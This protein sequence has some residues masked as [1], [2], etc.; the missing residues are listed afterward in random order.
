VPILVQDPD[1]SLPNIWVSASSGNQAV[2]SSTNI[3]I[4][5]R[6]NFLKGLTANLAAD[7]WTNLITFVPNANASG[8]SAITINVQEVDN[9]GNVLNTVTT[10]FNLTVTPRNHAPTITAIPSPQPVVAGK[11]STNIVFSVADPDNGNPLVITASSSDQTLVRDADIVVDVPSGPG[12]A[13]TVRVTTQPGVQGDA[14]ITLSVRDPGGLRAS[15]QFT[16]R[17]TPTRERIFSNTCQINIRDNNSA[18]PYPSVINVSGFSG[19]VS[20]V[21]VSLN[22][23]THSFPDDVDVLLVSPTGQKAIVMSDAGGGSAAVN[24]TLKFDDE[25]TSAIPDNTA[26]ANG[27]YQPANYEG[28]NT[29]NFVSPAPAGPYGTTLAA[30]NGGSPNGDWSLYVIDDTPSDAGAITNGW[31]IGI[32]TLPVLVGLNDV[33]SQEDLPARVPFT[34]AEESFGNPNSFTFSVSSTNTALVP[35][36]TN[37]IIVSGTGTNRTVTVVPNPNANSVNTGGP[38]LITITEETSGASAS[39]HVTFTEVNDIP[40]ITQ[41]ADQSLSVGSFVVVTNFNFADVETA[42]K[43]LVVTITSS[44]PSVIPTNNVVIVGNELRIFSGTRTGSSRIGITVADANGGANTMTFNVTVATGPSPVFAS[45]SGITINDNSRATP[46]PSTIDVRGV[47]GTVSNL[48]VTLT[49]FTHS[50]PDDVDILLVGPNNQGVVVLSDAGAG[51]NAQSSLTNAWLTFTDTASQSAPDNSGLQSFSVYRPTDYEVSANEFATPDDAGTAVPRGPYSAT[52]S[53]AFNGINPNGIWKLYVQDDASPDAGAITGWTLKI[54]LNEVG[55]ELIG[56]ADVT[57]N[58]DTVVLAPFTFSSSSAPDS[59]VIN[60][61][62][63]NSSLV[64]A[65][66]VGGSGTNRVLQISLVPDAFGTSTITVEA[67]DAAGTRT[68]TFNLTVLNVPDAPVL[69]PIAAQQTITNTPVTV[70][71]NVS[72]I[73]TAITNLN[74]SATATGSVISGIQ[75]NNSNGSNVTM[76]ITPI[77]GATGTSTV[78]V[79]VGDGDNVARQSFTFRVVQPGPPVLAPISDATVNEGSP[80][81]IPL[82]VSDPD[83]DLASLTF[84]GRTTGTNLIRDITFAL[85]TSNTVVMTV[86]PIPGA[87]GTDTVTVSVSDGESVVRQSFFVTILP[88]NEPPVL[89]AIPNQ[90]TSEDNAVTI[91]L[92]FSDRETPNDNLILTGSSS[93][94]SL[95]SSVTFLRSGGG[96]AAV[97]NLVTNAFG[98][99][100]VT[101][102]VSD[103]TNVTSRTFLLTVVSVLEPPVLGPIADVTVTSTNTTTVRVPLTVSDPD[104]TLGQLSF[105]GTP[106]STNVVRNVQFEVTSSN[107]VAIITLGAGAQGTDRVTIS[108]S[109]GESTPARQSFNVTVRTTTTTAPTLSVAKVGNNLNITITG[110]AG[111]TFNLEG[112]TDLVTWSVVGP[113]TIGSNGTA[114]VQVPITG[115]FRFFRARQ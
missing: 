101:I 62:A 102:N 23:F 63:S 33:T 1:T 55:P 96:A 9:N 11:S 52:F 87:T 2:I 39:F 86:T 48:T 78:T 35:S 109:D 14:V 12:G 61:T 13:R 114:Q 8:S 21:T 38:T 105:V 26:L 15:T 27:T 17:V 68:R 19:N 29:D 37:N 20:K 34:I 69:G 56:L 40:T 81:V 42:K 25:A 44:D 95:V 59:V 32:T 111:A 80:I 72:D 98:T 103:A 97:I 79:S 77:A 104:N 45:T 54:D 24:L 7:T 67:T 50:F 100:N 22:G 49:G 30:F 73:D 94:P 90:T 10:G 106:G 92:N 75:F 88:N 108:V 16:V 31:S 28:T 76:T 53:G 110:Q 4:A 47:N 66:K 60:A 46:Y 74:F 36:S 71:L 41:V 107:A 99:A 82:V 85:T 115:N 64:S 6:T 112:S 18:D 3:L 113:V 65:T 91:V 58:E 43:D 83:N 93:N 84:A 70:A 51:G 5:G 57:G 89:A